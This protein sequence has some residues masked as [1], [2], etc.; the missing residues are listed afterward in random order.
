LS[1]VVT[2]ANRH[3]SVA[4]E[5]LLKGRIV[6]PARKRKQ[7]LCLDAAYVGKE[8]TAEENGFAPHIRP[9]GEEKKLI[10]T[11][12]K[13][14]ARRWVVELSHSWFNRF[15]KLVPR[16]EKTDLSYLAFTTLAASMIVLRK[17][18]VIYR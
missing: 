8:A 3:D 7:N 9:R 11:N 6:S 1:L 4:L 10:A 16:Y 14:K 2:G 12:P 5:P 13:F 17:V 18:M 15:R